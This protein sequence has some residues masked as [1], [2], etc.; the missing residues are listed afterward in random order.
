[1]NGERYVT[2]D[3]V[4]TRVFEAGSGPTLLLIHGGQF[5]SPHLAECAYDWCLSFDELSRSFRVIAY[6]KPGQGRSENPP[7]EDDYTMSFVVDHAV[8]LVRALGLVRV[9][10][11]G[12]S[13]GGLPAA[14]LAMDHPEL[15][16][17]CTVIDSNTLAPGIGRNDVVM[18][19]VPEPRLGRAAQRWVA[20]R[21]S[22]TPDHIDG[23]WL[24]EAVAVGQLP[25]YHDAVRLMEEEDLRGRRFLPDL[26]WQKERTLSRMRAGDL[27]VPFMLLWG[28]DDPTAT[29][30]QAH[31]LFALAAAGQPRSEMHVVNRAGHFS[32]REQPEHF[33]TLVRAF[34]ARCPDGR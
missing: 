1:M 32:Y 8:A 26:A 23:E 28:Y 7:R 20:E 18:A 27:R 6:D 12:H 2:V 33:H 19:G 25:S 11:V 21:Y 29:L 14:R 15:V 17:T 24:D 30:E 4:R 13:R 16:A 31:G 10:V 22:Y 9:H 5:G 34:V 3:G